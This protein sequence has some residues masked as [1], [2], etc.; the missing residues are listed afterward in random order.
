LVELAFS[1]PVE[2]FK[3]TPTAKI[4]VIIDDLGV[5]DLDSAFE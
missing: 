4:A 3:E 2:S 1:F 5:I